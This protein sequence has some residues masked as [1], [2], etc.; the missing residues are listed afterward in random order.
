M[1]PQAK[2]SMF[3]K[4]HLYAVVSNSGGV[5]IKSGDFKAEKM[6][7]TVAST[8]VITLVIDKLEP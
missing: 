8:D 5:G 1:T 6:N 2:L 7:V 4:V 3:N